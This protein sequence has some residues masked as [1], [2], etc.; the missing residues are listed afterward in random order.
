M[1]D[2]INC[3]AEEFKNV[4]FTSMKIF[5]SHSVKYSKDGKEEN[6]ITLS[7]SVF[8]STHELVGRK[9]FKFVNDY[10]YKTPSKNLN[11]LSCDKMNPCFLLAKNVIL[12][13]IYQE[14]MKKYNSIVEKI[15]K[16][17]KYAQLDE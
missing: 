1:Q 6:V 14:Y 9:I 3:L 15:E 8:T 2:L 4:E 5:P 17:Q 11:Y 10:I 16:L 12:D 13:E 7:V